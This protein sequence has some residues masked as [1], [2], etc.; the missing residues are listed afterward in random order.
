MSEKALLS[1]LAYVYLNPVRAGMADTPETSSHTSVQERLLP[2]F[3]L[4]HAIDDQT[5][6]VICSISGHH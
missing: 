5:N 6:A 3:E 4:Q 2:E 1:C